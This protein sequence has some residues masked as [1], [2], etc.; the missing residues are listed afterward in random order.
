MARENNAEIVLEGKDQKLINTLKHSEAEI[1]TFG[2]RTVAT[3]NHVGRSIQGFSDRYMGAL[4]GLG[5]AMGAAEIGKDMM[6]FDGLL[7]RIGRTGGYSGQQLQELR[8]DIMNLI[9][10]PTPLTKG[11]WAEIAGQMH[12]AGMALKDIR[13]IMPQVGKGVV[14]SHTGP[15]VYAEAM[16]DFVMKYKVAIRDLP[17][18]QEQLNQA[19]KWEDVRKNPEAFLQAFSGLAKTIQLTG[20]EGVRNVTPLIAAIG[21]LSV[22]TGGSE[23]AAGSMEALLNGTFRLA[24]RGDM[25]K[26]LGKEGISFFDAKG[27]IKPMAEL[28]DN[29]KKLGEA[30]A[31][32]GK[33]ID[34]VAMN[35]FGRPEAGKAIMGIVKNYDEIKAKQD[36]LQKSS[37]SLGR[38]FIIETTAMSSKLKEFVNQMDKFKTDHMQ[39]ALQAVKWALD[40]LNRHPMIA[41]GLIVGLLGAGGIMILEK[42]S[43]DSSPWAGF[44]REIGDIWSGGKGGKGGVAGALGKTSGAIPVYVVNWGGRIGG[45]KGG[46]MPGQR[47]AETASGTALGKYLLQYGGTALGTLEALGVG[48]ASTVGGLVTATILSIIGNELN[49]EKLGDQGMIDVM[50][51]RGWQGSAAGNAMKNEI[52]LNIQG[53]GPL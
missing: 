23:S 21:Q 4:A 5:V 9:G 46:E 16:A 25:L 39:T 31:R 19:M 33:D 3:F 42:V 41:K 17:A 14:A 15:G 24:K 6:E 26:A 35:V 27:K 53:L 2:T 51:Q 22:I 28:L 52:N 12:N 10:T 43:A 1:K 50:R 45:G 44:M 29:Y 37:G 30:A 20:S 40:E 13:D 8:G 18:L 32:H 48:A 11:D 47:T 7:R 38:D 36:A 49:R 34:A